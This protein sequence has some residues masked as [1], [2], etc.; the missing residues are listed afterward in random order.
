MESIPGLE[1]SECCRCGKKKKKKK[2]KGKRNR[3]SHCGSV[4]MKPKSI[5]EDMG[6]IPGPTKWVKDPAL[7][8][9]LYRPAA[10]APICPLAW[11]LP[12]AMGAALKK[13]RERKKE[14]CFRQMQSIG[15]H[16]LEKSSIRPEKKKVLSGNWKIK[17]TGCAN[18]MEIHLAFGQWTFGSVDVQSDFLLPHSHVLHLLLRF[19]W[20]EKN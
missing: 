18:G 3:S 5:H 12:Y 4:V 7:P 10:L 14:T 20:C 16:Q 15:T 8:W 2:K 13:K 6:S 1:T 17:D 9:A 19:C 11:E